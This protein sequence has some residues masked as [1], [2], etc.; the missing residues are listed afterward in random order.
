MSRP[1]LC[2]RWKTVRDFPDY[3]VSDRGNIKRISGYYLKPRGRTVE[4]FEERLVEVR[5]GY[6][7]VCKN[8]K[9]HE[10]S[11]ARFVLEAF[12]RFPPRRFKRPVAQH[13]DEDKMNN[14]LSNLTWGASQRIKKPSKYQQK[15]ASRKRAKQILKD[16]KQQR[17]MMKSQLTKIKLDLQSRVTFE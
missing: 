8:G 15:L 11:L 12:E 10:A 13:L 17:I 7:N 16:Q 4:F 6:V 14:A 3:Q 1:V 5:N 2:E 9:Y